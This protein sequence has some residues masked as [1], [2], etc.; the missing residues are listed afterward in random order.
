M[1]VEKFMLIGLINQQ[2][3]TMWEIRRDHIVHTKD[4]DEDK[5]LVINQYMS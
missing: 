2:Y 1:G 5:E 3:I 4:G